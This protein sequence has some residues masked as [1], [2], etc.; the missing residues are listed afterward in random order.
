[1]KRLLSSLAQFTAHA[2]SGVADALID[3]PVIGVGVLAG[4]IL[5]LIWGRRR[6]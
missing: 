2:L 6:S 4:G 3:Y 5:G 1:M